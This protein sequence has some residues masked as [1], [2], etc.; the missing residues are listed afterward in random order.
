MAGSTY[1]WHFSERRYNGDMRR[2]TVLRRILSR[3]RALPALV[4]L[5]LLFSQFVTSAYACPSYQGQANQAAVDCHGASGAAEM[6]PEQALLC[7]A[8][9]DDAAQSTGT[10]GAL[11]LTQATLLLYV[12]PAAAETG[13]DGRHS[14]RLL[15]ALG[16]PPPGWPPV[17]LLHRVLRN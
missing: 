8:S 1:T 9:C 10:A 14:A 4:I 13:R 17:Y 16:E 15:I 3:H 5:A 11:D 6:D 12:L 7:Q 2:K